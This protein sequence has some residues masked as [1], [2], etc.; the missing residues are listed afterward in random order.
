MTSNFRKN[1]LTQINKNLLS[2]LS[3]T[4][5]ITAL[6]YNSWRNELSEQNRNIR[7]SGFEI[8]KESAHLQLVLDQL[9]YSDNKNNQAS[10]TIEGWVKIRLI[11]SLSYFMS[12]LVKLKAD[13]L[14]N[15]WE[16]HSGLISENKESNRKVSLANEQLVMAVRIQLALLK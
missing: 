6:S 14:F 3:L 7:F 12:P 9:T 16:G 2:V 4:I 15:L 13:N 10:I 1:L 11:P 5:A 8:I